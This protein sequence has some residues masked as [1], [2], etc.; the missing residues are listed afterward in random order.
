MSNL[1]HQ[2]SALSVTALEK[3]GKWEI[4]RW[5]CCTQILQQNDHIIMSSCQVIYNLSHRIM[6]RNVDNH[7]II[8]AY[9]LVQW[10]ASH[11]PFNANT[12]NCLVC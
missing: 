9:C 6:V 11:L 2:R 7:L 8:L 12:H 3:K 5:L 10:L 1:F 4:D